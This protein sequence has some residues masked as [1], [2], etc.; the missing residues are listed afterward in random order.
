[1]NLEQVFRKGAA[2]IFKKFSDAVHVCSYV[3]VTLDNGMDAKV[4]TTTNGVPIIFSEFN[5]N[6]RRNLPFGSLIQPTD[7]KGLVQG[8]SLNDLKPTT[9]DTVLDTTELDSL[10]AYNSYSVVAF[11]RDPLGVVY[12]LLLRGV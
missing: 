7:I 6:D 4:S 2:L 9:R 10:G 1:M 8:T 12:T 5:E 11:S 3:A